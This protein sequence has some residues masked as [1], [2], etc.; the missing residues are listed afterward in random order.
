MALSKKHLEFID[1]YFLCRFNQ[2]DA[3]MK[4]YP[5]SSYDAARANSA[6]LIADDNIQAEI[7]RRLRE[8]H[9]TADMV[10]HNL[11]EQANADHSRYF[12]PDGHI[13]TKKLIADGKGHLIQEIEPTK[14]GRKIRFYDAQSANVHIGKALGIFN[15]RVEHTG[16]GGGP[17][18]FTQVEVQLERSK[19][20]E[21]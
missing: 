6:R 1:N 8:K 15:D 14:Y 5:K 4:T 13:D 2:T 19:P 16:P 3:Y 12:T 18:E 7:T 9:L 17:I 10:L 20:V 11:A 21:D